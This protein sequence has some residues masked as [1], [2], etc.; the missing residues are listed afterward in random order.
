MELNEYQR[1]AHATS[2]E[3]LIGDSPLLYPVLGLVGESGELADKVKKLYRDSGGVMDDDA[4]LDLMLE[5]G[6]VLWYLSELATALNVELET[7][8][9]LN[10]DKLRD[11]EHRGV[12]GGSGDRR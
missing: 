3:T 10:L 9:E 5:A 4:K 8:A 2:K 6:D 12:I 11:R 1:Q 7:I